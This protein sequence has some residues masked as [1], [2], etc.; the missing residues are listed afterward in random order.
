VDKIVT[1]LAGLAWGMATYMIVPVLVIENAGVI[2]SIRRSG[3]LLRKNWG[4]QIAYG[5]TF[6]WLTLLFLIPLVVL[7][8]IAMNYSLW[9]LPVAIAFGLFALAVM[10]AL[11]GV[12]VV[13]LYRYAA[14]GEAPGG[15]SP[16]VL[17]R[18]F[19]PR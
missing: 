8:A 11:R 9:M 3:A 12:F 18:A 19:R 7:G 1:S 5:L 15:Y 14:S 17:Q 13:A 16:D 2:E 6:G 10:A 4:Q